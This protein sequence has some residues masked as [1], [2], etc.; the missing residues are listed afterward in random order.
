MW[1]ERLSSCSVDATLR[2]PNGSCSPERSLL[3]EA[4]YGPSTSMANGPGVSCAGF[5][6]RPGAGI[7]CFYRGTRGGSEQQ[8]ETYFRSLQVFNL[9]AGSKPE[10]FEATPTSIGPACP[11][12][13]RQSSLYHAG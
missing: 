13:A 1:G 9:C 2:Y 6:A 10:W 11:P 7:D 8:H 12:H 5:C 3:H 4:I